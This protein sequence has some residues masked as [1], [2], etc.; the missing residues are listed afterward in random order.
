MPS[1]SHRDRI[2][3]FAADPESVGT[4]GPAPA[5]FFLHFG[6][7]ASEGRAAIQRHTEFFRATGMDFVKIQY[8]RTLPPHPI[9]KPSDWRH[10]PTLDE[11]F[12]EPAL[13]VVRG[14][15]DE[16][17]REAPVVV[18]L[19]SAFMCAGHVARNAG[20]APVVA[21]HLQEDPDAVA[22]GL[23]AVNSS[24]LK[25]VDACVRIGVDGFYHSTQGGESGRF[26]DRRLFTDYIQPFDLRLMG[27]ANSRCPFNIL[28]IC[29]YHR[30]EVGGYDDLTQ[31]ASYPGQIVNC[32]LETGSRTWTAAE[33]S[34]AFR[35]PFFGGMDRLGIL[36]RGSE[37]EARE[38]ARRALAQVSAG[39]SLPYLLGADCT[40]PADT[41]W[42]NLRAAIEEA[43]RWPGC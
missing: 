29:D 5:A 7:Q 27:E 21:R 30:S 32:S 11:V 39:Q 13:N 26:S 9:E 38:A 12:F 4:E 28:H 40:V 35:R 17:K 1:D 19:Y 43:H 16:L 2:L 31:F 41:P 20:G 33:V 23:E 36:A 24:L 18:T 42:G 15:V 3:A 6:P 34:R 37:S 25:F 10:I 8:E 14:L 22:A